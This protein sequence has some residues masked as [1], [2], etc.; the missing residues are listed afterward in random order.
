[1]TKLWKLKVNGMIAN[2]VERSVTYY[3]VRTEFF[4]RG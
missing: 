1:V 4:I 3:K 2:L